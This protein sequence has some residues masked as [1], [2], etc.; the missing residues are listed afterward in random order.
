MNFHGAHEVRSGGM[1]LVGG[2]LYLQ[3]I[4]SYNWPEHF[5]FSN[6][7]IEERNAIQII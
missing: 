4:R 3:I 7:T 2:F 5:P 6:K 1:Q